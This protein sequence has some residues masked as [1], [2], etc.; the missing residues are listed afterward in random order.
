MAPV[1]LAAALIAVSIAPGGVSLAST[2]RASKSQSTAFDPNK[3]VTITIA[4][5][6]G[7]TPG[8]AAAFKGVVQNFEKKYPK[9]TINLETEG[10]NA[11][12]ESID[13][14]ASSSSAPDVFMLASSGYGPGFYSLAKG[15]DLANLDSYATQY[16]WNTR[17]SS[18]SLGVFR[19]DRKTSTWGAGSL[20]GL[21]EQNTMIGVFYNKKLLN[22]IGYSSPP[23]TYAG[24]EA[25]LAAAKA[26]G[27]TPI[28]ATSDAYIHIEMALWD[29]FA[30]SAS[31]VNDWVYGES[32]SFASPA[33]LRAADTLVDW[34]NKGYLSAG[35]DGTAYETAVGDLT[36]GTALYFFAG[37]WLDGTVQQSLGASGGFF[38]LP[39]EYSTSPVGGGPS[40]PLVVSSKSKHLAVDAAFLNFFNSTEESNYLVQHGWGPPGA[41][42]QPS[43]AKTLPVTATVLNILKNV[44]APKGV[45]TTPYINWAG[46]TIGNDIPADLESLIAEKISPQ[47]YVDAIQSDWTQFKSQR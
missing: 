35:S 23:S 39:S 19:F 38:Q 2:S 9:V 42:V 32:G 30:P 1:G 45:G 16:G 41:T 34:Q 4:D 11:Y 33:N 7:D 31:S 40:S 5:G 37:P 26:K 46:P 15:G 43:V 47:Q 36:S 12:N 27:I 18:T 24:F 25:T 22:E 20:Y 3:P 28:A 10:S 29:A 44:E 21:P 13:L 8:V 6:W 14:K 17:F